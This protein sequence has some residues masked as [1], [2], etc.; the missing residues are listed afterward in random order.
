MAYISYDCLESKEDEEREK[1]IELLMAFDHKQKQTKETIRKSSP[2]QRYFENIFNSCCQI[3]TKYDRS[4]IVNPFYSPKL[5]AIIINYLYIVPLWTGVMLNKNTSHLPQFKT[6]KRTTN[7]PVENHFGHD[8]NSLLN[9]R[10]EVKP[11][12]YVARKYR[13]ILSKFIEFYM[14]EISQERKFKKQNID[15]IE[16]WKDKKDFNRV[17]SFYYQNIAN[18]DNDTDLT[19]IS[20][21]EESK[22]ILSTHAISKDIEIE[23]ITFRFLTG[24]FFR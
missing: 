5:V 3:I 10:L 24:D 15:E 8:K 19:C 12:E 14:K 4:N 18:F 17:K 11:S 21:E 22:S 2:F 20:F 6:K 16:R 1:N 7:N 13:F 23:E 9:R